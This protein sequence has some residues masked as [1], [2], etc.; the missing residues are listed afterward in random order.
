MLIQSEGAAKL[1]AFKAVQQAA[2]IH[3]MGKWEK[4]VQIQSN[5]GSQDGA[6][7]SGDGGKK[8]GDD[9]KPVL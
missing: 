3:R 2:R 4:M 8:R 6:G 7:F 9:I 5:N 1:E